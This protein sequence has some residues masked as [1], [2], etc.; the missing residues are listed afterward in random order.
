MHVVPWV[1]V[2]L[3]FAV[4]AGA[5]ALLTAWFLEVLNFGGTKEARA[6]LGD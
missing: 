1:I 4:C 5:A 2:L 6:P 3:T